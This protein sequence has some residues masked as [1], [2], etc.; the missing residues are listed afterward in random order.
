ML[1]HLARQLAARDAAHLT[2]RRRENATPTAPRQTVDGV[3]RLLFCS[4]DYL[5]PPTTPPSSPR[6]KKAPPL[7]PA[8]AARRSSADL[9]ATPRA[10][11]A[12]C[13][14][15]RA[16]YPR[17]TGFELWHRLHGQPRHGL[18][19]RHRRRRIFSTAQPRQP[20][21]RRAPARASKRLYASVDEL[22]EQLAAS[23]AAHK[24]HR[25]RRRVQ[26]GRPPRPAARAAATRRNPQRPA[27]GGRR[28]RLRR[29]RPSGPR[30][31]RALQPAQRAPGLDGHARQGDRRGGA[32][33]AAHPT[34]I[35]WL[36][37]MARPFIFTTARLLRCRALL[38]AFDL[39][40]GPETTPAAPQLAALQRNCAMASP[41]S[42]LHAA[43]PCRPATHHPAR[44]HRLPTTRPSPWPR[45]SSRRPARPRHPPAHRA[46][47]ARALRITLC[48]DHA[49]ADVD[50]LLGALAA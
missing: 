17:R 24:A 15:G 16:A 40:E 26:H 10:G 11:R 9:D 13:R 5:G 46:G 1:D 33:I 34:V 37:Q 43:G 30:F 47:G 49:A 45:S 27:A 48:A 42:A 3:P 21:R 31:A 20:H 41:R 29:P 12:L 28:A 14:L 39:I 35:E 2:R 50:A 22:R 4:N 6:C 23:T 19:P 32:A 36:I 38:T 8:R 18:G 25:H 44:R 7:A